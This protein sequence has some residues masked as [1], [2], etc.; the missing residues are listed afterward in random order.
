MM[1]RPAH[2]FRNELLSQW[3]KLVALHTRWRNHPSVQCALSI[4]KLA[5]KIL[6]WLLRSRMP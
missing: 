6:I 3:E 1:S 2:S 4:A 5:G